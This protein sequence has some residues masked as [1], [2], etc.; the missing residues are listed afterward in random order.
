MVR[1]S[2]L[3]ARS[4]QPQ[5]E[6]LL[7]QFPAVAL[8]GPRQ[9]G[10]TTL[11]RALARAHGRIAVYL[12]LEMPSDLARLAD[13]GHYLAS[14]EGALVIL[15]E[16]HRLPGLFQVLRGLIDR[17]RAKGRRAGRFLLLGSASIDLL[18]QSSETLA[19]R[20]AYAE[21]TALL[22]R[23]LP[24]QRA[25]GESLWVRGGFPD[26]FLAAN[27]AASFEWRQAFV[28]TYLQRDIPQLGPR[29]PAETL[30]RFWT[31]LA[32]EQGQPINHARIAAGLA[33]SGQSG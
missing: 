25:K 17:G 4:A 3:I 12:D 8:L 16:I 14:Q 28:R 9:A 22:E 18:R 23:E 32:H 15:D 7:R 1:R 11:A 13:P 19:G 2:P 21:L 31:M 24:P 30:R 26:S 29:I 6:A 33:V 10:K 20:I 27:D 5:V